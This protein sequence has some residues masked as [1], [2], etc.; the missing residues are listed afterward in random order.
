MTTFHSQIPSDKNLLDL[1]SE[2]KTRVETLEDALIEMTSCISSLQNQI[3][4]VD[5]RIDIILEEKEEDN[6]RRLDRV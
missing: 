3:E 6:V 1:I 5:A 4:A 2:L